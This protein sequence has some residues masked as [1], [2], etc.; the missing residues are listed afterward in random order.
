MHSSPLLKSTTE[1]AITLD[2]VHELHCLNYLR[3]LIWPEKYHLMETLPRA[4]IHLDHCVDII[5]QSLQCSADI[6][7]MP[8]QRKENGDLGINLAVEHSCL[9][10]ESIHEWAEERQI[11]DEGEVYVN[12]TSDGLL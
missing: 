4:E 3:K 1:Y 11:W 6:T 5:R 8:W 9:D 2:V 7:P 10:W 12:G